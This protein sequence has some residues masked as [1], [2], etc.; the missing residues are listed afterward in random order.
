[1]EKTGSSRRGAGRVEL[2]GTGRLLG[3]GGAGEPVSDL[4]GCTGQGRSGFLGEVEATL[5]GHSVGTPDRY[6]CGKVGAHPASS[7]PEVD[8][9]ALRTDGVTQ[10]TSVEGKEGVLAFQGQMRPRKP[11]PTPAGTGDSHPC[12]AQRQPV[13]TFFSC[14]LRVIR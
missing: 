14:L 12:R 13:Q 9:R 3:S 6:L 5:V 7:R 11:P 4:G 2:D 10:D 8:L 1:M